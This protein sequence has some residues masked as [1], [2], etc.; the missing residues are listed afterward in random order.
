MA[1]EGQPDAAEVRLNRLL[2][3]ILETAVDALGFTAATVTAR[4][5]DDI[6]TVAAT[7]QRLLELDDAQYAGGGPCVQA[8]DDPDPIV[9]DDAAGS[10]ER[11]QHFAETAA[12]LGVSTSLSLH[13]PT[14]TEA[15]AASLNLYAHE[16]LRLSDEHIGRA[17]A[18]AEQ[19]AAT[20]QSVDA[21]RAT[22]RLARN[23]AQAMR[24]RGVIEQ[25]KGML[26]AADHIPADDAFHRLAV[27]SQ[28]TNVPVRE[29]ARRLV[30]ERSQNN[31]EPS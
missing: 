12:H 6:S 22:A 17:G 10:D 27:V 18:Y 2:N 20:L 29:I 1:D 8:L 28:N 19:L 16:R 5:G 3:L 24:T 9:L 30:E 31:D 11:W 26:M 7:D 23:L 13:V 14:D 4:H 15:V 25:A 21:Y